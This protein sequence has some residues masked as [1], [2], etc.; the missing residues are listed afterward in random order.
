MVPAVALYGMVC[1]PIF[2]EC[3]VTDD[4]SFGGGG[5][6]SA[7]FS[8]SIVLVSF[9]RSCATAVREL[10]PQSRIVARIV[11]RAGI[12]ILGSQEHGRVVALWGARFYTSGERQVKGTP[13]SEEGVS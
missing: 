3:S 4:S 9:S 10:A 6:G 7:G 12:G 2:M 5:V 13:R 1:P 8:F 11:S